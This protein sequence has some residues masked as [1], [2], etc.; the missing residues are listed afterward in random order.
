MMRRK[1]HDCVIIITNQL[2]FNINLFFLLQGKATES[3]PCNTTIN[4]PSLT[5][6][7]R[8]RKL[9]LTSE[10]ANHIRLLDLTQ[11]DQVEDQG[12]LH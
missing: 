3:T 8:K 9:Q 10:L 6:K 7:T 4:N 11:N 2:E 12:L 1:M 5:P